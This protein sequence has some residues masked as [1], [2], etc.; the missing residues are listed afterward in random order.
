MNR[1]HENAVIVT[2]STG[3]F[4]VFKTNRNIAA[5]GAE[6][7]GMDESFAKGQIRLYDEAINRA[8]SKPVNAAREYLKS[9]TV[10]WSDSRNNSFGGL[11]SGKEY[12]LQ[13]E[14]LLE[15]EKEMSA[16][17]MAREQVAEKMLFSQWD[18]LREQARTALNDQFR[19]DFFPDVHVVR[20]SFRWEVSIRPLWDIKD[21]GK[22]I[23]L[24][25]SQEIVDRALRDAEQAQNLK[26]ANAIG[27]IVD[28]VVDIT[29]NMINGI[30]SYSYDPDK[31]RSGNTLPKNPSWN[32]LSE[33]A[34]KMDSWASSLGSDNL[35]DAATQIRA[36]LSDVRSMG[37][38]DI[39]NA[40]SAMAGEDDR[41]RQHVRN[42]LSEI[43]ATASKGFDALDDFMS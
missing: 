42:K 22:D 21:I 13:A 37:G 10:P 28:D 6:A 9:V 16:F 14:R 25:A 38:G 23:R 27:S 43:T 36:L 4:G 30:D 34:N 15:F 18:V 17:R 26:I 8:I 24:K 1:V 32:N 3:S 12:L 31:P 41:A 39:S 33:L 2:F 29:S 20:Q 7:L 11:T 5:R 19:E 35:T 40:R